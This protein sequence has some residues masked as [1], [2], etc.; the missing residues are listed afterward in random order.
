MTKTELYEYYDQKISKLA[1]QEIDGEWTVVGKWSRTVIMD[2]G[3]I[4]I[5]ICNHS[6]IP[7]GLGTRKVRNM[8]AALSGYAGNETVREIT[9]EGYVQT[10]DKGVVLHN[11]ASLGIRIKRRVDPKMAERLRQWQFK[12]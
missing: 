3:L 1:I 11:L 12:S 8:L 2:S 4:D 7:A 6:D 9:G 10:W 5:W